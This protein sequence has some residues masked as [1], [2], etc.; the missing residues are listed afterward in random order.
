MEVDIHSFAQISDC[1]LYGDKAALH[2]GVN[3]YLNLCNVLE[4]IRNDPAIEFIVFTGDLTQDHSEQSYQLFYDAVKFIQ[5]SK[6]I[7]FLAGNHDEPAL[8]DKYL[9]A[10]PFQNIRTIANENWQIQLLGSKSATPAG[11]ISDEESS[12]LLN[13]IDKSKFQFILMHHHPI[14][15]GYFI[16]KHGLNKKES[17]YQ[18]LNQINS[19][20]AIGCGHIHNAFDLTLDIGTKSI[21]VFTC[22]ATSIQFDIHASTVENSGKPAGFRIY[23][24][25]DDG[26]I[27]SRVIFIS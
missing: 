23:E 10:E 26:L 17:F 21:P 1:H 15:V 25:H 27:N 12:R 7:Y 24:L 5:V 9:S 18:T 6:P 20:K 14:D 16:D 11:V 2:Y 4:L 19:L 3:V 8:F 22:P 13:V